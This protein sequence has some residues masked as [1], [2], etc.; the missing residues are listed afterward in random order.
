MLHPRLDRPPSARAPAFAAAVAILTP[1]LQGCGGCSET[2][3]V[4]REP[5]P[6]NDDGGDGLEGD[7]GSWLSMAVDLDG[8]PVIS[9]YHRSQGA[10]GFA[11][12][13]WTDDG[14]LRWRHEQVDGYPD[15]NG[16]DAGD[17]GKYT[18][19][20]V[21]A[22]G[23][24]WVAYQDVQNRNLR[25][26]TR[27]AGTTEW[28]SGSADVGAGA[29]PD[30]GH[31]AAMALDAYGSPIVAHYDAGAGQLRVTRWNG[32]AFSGAVVD[33]GEAPPS[34][35]GVTTEA[36]TGKYPSI[37]VQDNIE[38]IAYYDVAQGD[39]KLAW[40]AA[41]AYSIETIASEGDVGAWPD[42]V[43]DEGTLHIA[44]PDV[45][46]GD[47]MV[48][49]GSPG[50]WSIEVVDDGDHVGADTRIWLSGG[51][52]QIVYFDGRN[53]DMKQ[54]WQS[55]DGWQSRTVTDT[56]GALGFHNEVV[57]AN[58]TTWGACYDYTNRTLWFESLD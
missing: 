9:H 52:P 53:N 3:I 54:A 56:P 19:L 25:Y 15:E 41:G 58:G 22:D 43:I 6:F 10:V 35:S 8:A 2:N 48:A 45:T 47:L 14:E 11:T 4:P 26:A 32:T 18:T 39:L 24:V 51:K 30:A 49:S 34:D 1:A 36:N 50:A 21:A 31:Y 5:V 7:W 23:R 20:A 27:P 13:T 40:G 57:V 37:A 29:A 42:V 44:Y 46:N 12:A 17:R 28:E 33:A 38:Y 16:F 55:G